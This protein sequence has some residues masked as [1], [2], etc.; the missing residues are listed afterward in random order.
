MGKIDFYKTKKLSE[1]TEEEWEQVCMRCGKCCMHK[2]EDKNY[3]YFSNMMCRQF[4][5][6]KNCCSCYESRLNNFSCKKVD[7]HALENNLELLPD[8]CAYRLLFEGKDL[9]DYHPLITGNPL[10]PTLA[11]ATVKSLPVYSQ[12]V[13]SKALYDLHTTASKENWT[14]EKFLVEESLI[15]QKYQQKPLLVFPLIKK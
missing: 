4:D 9:P 13:L 8:T 2:Y 7:M 14:E 6:E 11:G 3:I 5:L 12:N 1:F 10:S 15:F